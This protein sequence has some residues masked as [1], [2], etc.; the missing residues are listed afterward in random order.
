MTAD[1]TC[2]LSWIDEEHGVLTWALRQ[3]LLAEDVHFL[4]SHL[5]MQS[6]PFA[7][8]LSLETWLFEAHLKDWHDLHTRV[9]TDFRIVLMYD[10]VQS[11]RMQDI[12]SCVFG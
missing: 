9:L 2:H 11:G 6:Q 7:V 3:S 8:L 12:M 5:R 10:T 1:S 4:I